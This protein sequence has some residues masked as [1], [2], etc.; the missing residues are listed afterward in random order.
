[1][2]VNKNIKISTNFQKAHLVWLLRELTVFYH[3]PYASF[4]H[5]ISHPPT[6]IA[7]LP[8]IY[9]LILAFVYL[10][11]FGFKKIVIDFSLAQ[12]KAMFWV[13][14]HFLPNDGHKM[15]LLQW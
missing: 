4:A 6:I 12:R 5:R 10:R 1:M 3:L 9:R 13:E 7:I 8:K 14:H 2:K 11:N 15:A